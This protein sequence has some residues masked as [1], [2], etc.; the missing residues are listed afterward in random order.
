MESTDGSRGG[1][2]GT[3]VV[4]GDGLG[5]GGNEDAEDMKDY[6]LEALLLQTNGSDEIN[7][8]DIFHEL[9]FLKEQM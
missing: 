8:T 4:D 5:E 6:Y 3:A 2:N 7:D 9:E 1:G